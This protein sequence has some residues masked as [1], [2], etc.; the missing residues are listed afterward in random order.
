[1]DSRGIDTVSLETGAEVAD[2]LIQSTVE[3]LLIDSHD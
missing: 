3:H 2:E 1:M